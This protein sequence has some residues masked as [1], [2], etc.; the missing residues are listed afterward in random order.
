M[1]TSVDLH[2]TTVSVILWFCQKFFFLSITLV[3]F[4]IIT[5]CSFNILFLASSADRS[6]IVSWGYSSTESYHSFICLYVSGHVLNLFSVRLNDPGNWQAAHQDL[7]LN[8][9]QNVWISSCFVDVGFFF[10]VN[11]EEQLSD[12]QRCSLSAVTAA[13]LRNNKR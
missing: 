10:V 7:M 11:P 9:I 5:Y 6:M 1:L 2:N 12:V 3:H 13:E 4:W 8:I